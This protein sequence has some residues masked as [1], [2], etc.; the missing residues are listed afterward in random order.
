[1]ELCRFILHKQKR[2]SINK[3]TAVPPNIKFERKNE[4]RNIRSSDQNRVE[5]YSVKL[6]EMSKDFEKMEIV[7]NRS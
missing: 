5:I 3:R 6:N 1:M 7:E 4:T 2:L